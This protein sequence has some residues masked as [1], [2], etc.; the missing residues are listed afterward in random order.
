MKA[1]SVTTLTS[2]DDAAA[3]PTE[4]EEGETTENYVR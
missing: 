3:H 2:A 1:S 4:T